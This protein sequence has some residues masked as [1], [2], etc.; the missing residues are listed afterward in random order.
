MPTLGQ[1]CVFNNRPTPSSPSNAF[2]VQI[3]FTSGDPELKQM[4]PTLDLSSKSNQ[5]STPGRKPIGG[6]L[7]GWKP[8]NRTHSAALAI[9]ILALFTPKWWAR[10]SNDIF[11]SDFVTTATGL[12]SGFTTKH[13]TFPCSTSH[14]Q[15]LASKRLSSPL[16]WA[17][18]RTSSIPR[19]VGSSLC[20]S[21][22]THRGNSLPGTTLSVSTL[23]KWVKHMASAAAYLSWEG[24]KGRAPQALH[25]K[26]LSK[27]RPTSECIMLARP[28]LSSCNSMYG[29]TSHV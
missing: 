27:V 8:N 10:A 1:S 6:K 3:K 29:C 11:M 25:C 4:S 21:S 17:A 20:A 26:V 14:P 9:E 19:V 7:P 12:L 16:T 18:S 28:R 22:C 13:T 5:V 15:E 24:L 2:Q 23:N